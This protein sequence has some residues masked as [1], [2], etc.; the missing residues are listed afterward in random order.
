[1]AR[2][3]SKVFHSIAEFEAEAENATK[4]AMQSTVNYFKK[5]LLEFADDAIYKNAYNRKW[6]VRTGWLK[7]ENAVEAYIFKN[8]KNSW[9]GGVKF[10]KAAY[11]SISRD[12]FQHGN[13]S[14]YLEMGSYLEIMNNSSLLHD[15][16]WNFPTVKQ[17]D[18]GS[19]YYDFLAELDDAQYGFQAVF[20]A[21]FE[22]YLKSEQT[23]RITIPNIPKRNKSIGSVGATSSSTSQYS[24]VGGRNINY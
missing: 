1:M 9:G 13:T 23:G 15:N 19:F 11:D 16:P 5:M 8:M 10:N 7:N 24:S 2:V 6:Y 20:Y 17:I 4:K 18:R 21:F 3:P 22:A 12:T 14:D